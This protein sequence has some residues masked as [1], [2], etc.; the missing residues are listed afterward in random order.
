MSNEDYVTNTHLP[1]VMLIIYAIL[2]FTHELFY[3]PVFH[4]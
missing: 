3:R 4:A 2:P 1:W